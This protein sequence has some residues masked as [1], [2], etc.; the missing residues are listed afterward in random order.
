MR[1]GSSNLTCAIAAAAAT[2]T[3]LLATATAA[4]QQ[5]PAGADPAAA[6]EVKKSAKQSEQIEAVVVTAQKRKEDASK[7]P[8]S[9][10]VI[11]GEELQA[12]HINNFADVT[13]AMPNIS[14]SGAS[15]AGAGLSNIEIRGISSAAGSATVGVYLDDVSMTTRNLYSMGSS[16]PKFFDIDRIEVLRGPQGTL[17]GASSM[18]GTIKFI[19]NQPNLKEREASV[20]SEVS[21]TKGGGTN[22]TVNGVVNQPLIPGE[23]ALRI[24]IQT[25]HESGYIDQVSP[26]TGNVI[27]SGINSQDSSVVKLAM[28][29]QPTRNLSIT[30]SVFY[31]EVNS[32]DI[33]A[34]YLALP[35][36]QTSKL[37]REPGNDRLLVPSLTVNYDMGKADLVSVSSFYQRTFNRTQDGTTVN[38]LGSAV[39]D[40]PPGLAAAIGALPS[41]VYLQNQVRQFSQEFRVASKPYDQ[42]VSPFTWL[43]GVYYANLHTNVTDNEP[44]FGLNATYA[45]FGANPA[46]PG[47]LGIAFPND[48]S[49]FSERHYR[50]EQKAVFGEL[51]YYFVPTLHGTVGLRYLQATDSLSRN[52]D[53]YWNG[54]PTSSSVSSSS[55]KLTPKFSLIWEV[56]PNNT[57]Y[58]SATEGFR[59]GGNT[60][61]IPASLCASDFANLGITEAPT[62]FKS[63]K[64]WSYELGNKSRL[65]GNRLSVNA[66][67]FY[68]QWDGLQQDIQLPGCGFDYETNVG[69]AKSYGAEFE[70]KGKPTSNILLGLSGGYTKATLSSDVP[71]LKAH[72][73]DPIQGVPKYNVSLT[74]QYSFNLPGDYYG[75]ARAAA[76]WTGSSHGTLVATDPDY[77]R[78]AYSTVDASVGATYDRW[79]L[80][81]FVKNLTNSDKVIQRPNV[82][83][84]S[85]G[86][87]V[88]PRTIGVSL[89]GKI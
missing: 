59:L 33:D 84:V 29:W 85:E 67:V 55:S 35:K 76:H 37:V 8:L 57:V 24:G 2:S 65:L 10:S 62:S 47:Q 9:I 61:P 88:A 40:T 81:L 18:G 64:L 48:N 46:D 26:T 13:R 30:P 89:A 42:N 39:P 16:E 20:Y 25:G 80:T 83:S 22:Y 49:Y 12:A 56:D 50:T 23:L 78:P 11:S 28:K 68:I 60:R 77:Q 82:Q 73:G 1:P 87:R 21:G 5:L 54:G 31:Q 66:S 38:N 75:F 17:Y 34:S 19:S 44:I 43:G 52:G 32:K 27:A 53:D 71:S 51:N 36:N 15:G 72:A 41:A 74:G 79:E 4:A 69:K 70:I 63:D 86:Y 6:P 3:L 45:A 14:F 58:T 7:V